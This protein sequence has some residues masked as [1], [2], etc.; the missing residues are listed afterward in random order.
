[1]GSVVELLVPRPGGFVV[2]K[3]NDQVEGE[4]QSR[5]VVNQEGG[6]AYPAEANVLRRYEGYASAGISERENLQPKGPRLSF[7]GEI[8]CYR[9]R[10]DEQCRLL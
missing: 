7:E 9:I 2:E 3:G 6:L 10:Q 5:T 1:M 8:P 4:Q